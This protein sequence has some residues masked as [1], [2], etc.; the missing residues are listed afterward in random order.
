MTFQEAQTRFSAIVNSITPTM[1]SGGVLQKQRDLIALENS[2]PASAEFDVIANAISD[3]SPKLTGM[4]A[5]GVLD[6]LKSR[7]SSVQAASSLLTQVADDANSNAKALTFEKPKLV[8]AAL[9]ETVAQLQELRTAAK[10]GDV[11]Q[12]VSKVDAL[13]TLIEHVR[14]SIKAS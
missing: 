13:A 14:S 9:N 2:L 12:A 11:E 6:S 1:S 4:V 10:A 5:Q 7:E 3:F 8:A